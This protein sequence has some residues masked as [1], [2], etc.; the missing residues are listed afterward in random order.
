MTTE[1]IVT[2]TTDSEAPKPRPRIAVLHH[3]DADGFGAA[4]AIWKAL[5]DTCDLQFIRVQY[6]QEP[7]WATLREFAPTKIF[8]VDFSYKASILNEFSAAY[9]DVTVID[10]HATALPELQAWC[11]VEE[12]VQE[13][14]CP[15]ERSFFF[16]LNQSG[17]ALTWGLFHLDPNWD[18]ELSP[19]TELHPSAPLPDILAYVQDRDLWRFCLENS[20][21]INAFIATLSESFEEWDTFYTPEAYT[22]GRAIL[23]FQDRQIEHLVKHAKMMFFETPDG[24]TYE[25]PVV[26]ATENISELGHA[27]FAAFPNT[28]FTVSYC[29][30]GGVRIFSLRSQTGFDV[31]KIAQ[32]FGGGGHVAAAGFTQFAPTILKRG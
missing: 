5:K 8:I 4:Y 18:P 19:T 11:G 25:V 20:K 13:Y 21:E 16:D 31:S 27:L 17:C 23:K 2:K 7:P 32:Q 6:S 12:T 28:P 3:N 22:C 9:T 14:S 24:K 29:D 26:N 1:P 10:H 30:N 15:G